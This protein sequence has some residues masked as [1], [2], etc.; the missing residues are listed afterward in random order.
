MTTTTPRL[1]GN[2]SAR[3][4]D[5]AA[6]RAR[7]HRLEGQ[8]RGVERMLDDDRCCLDLLTQLAAVVA[9]A[10]A[11][12]LLILEDHLRDCVLADDGADPER[13]LT[14]LVATIERFQRSLA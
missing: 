4:A 7:L 9:A 11:T 13:R 12:G 14:E 10:R 2:G 3:Q 8:V 5:K 1:P 6:I